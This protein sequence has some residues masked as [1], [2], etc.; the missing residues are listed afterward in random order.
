VSGYLRNVIY[1]GSFDGDEVEVVMRPLELG[2]ALRLRKLPEDADQAEV[3]ADLLKRYAVS[4]KGIRAADG[5]DVTLEEMLGGS[6]FASVIASAAMELV[7]RASP[8]S[9]KA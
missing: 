1:K 8:K 9:P 5:S 2:D 7:T 3:L 6:Y 4:V